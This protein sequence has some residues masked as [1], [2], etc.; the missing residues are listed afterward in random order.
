MSSVTSIILNAWLDE[1]LAIDYINRAMK[2]LP[3]VRVEDYAGGHKAMQSDILMGAYS[4]MDIP[5]FLKVFHSAPWRDP[6]YIQLFIKYEA[7]E[8]FSIITLKQEG[9]ND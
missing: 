5:A 7:D 4:Y 1:D 6:E 3:L 2:T 8:A 9:T